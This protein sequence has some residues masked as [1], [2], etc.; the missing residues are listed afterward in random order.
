MQ[1][2]NYTQNG[3]ENEKCG[4]TTTNERKKNSSKNRNNLNFISRFVQR[5][6]DIKSGDFSM[7]NDFPS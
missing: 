3:S 2:E 5:A 7:K 1:E 4:R 6:N